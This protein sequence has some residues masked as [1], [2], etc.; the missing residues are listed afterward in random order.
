MCVWQWLFGVSREE[1]E[2]ELS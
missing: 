1:V 2:E